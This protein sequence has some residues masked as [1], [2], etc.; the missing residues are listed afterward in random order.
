[1][2]SEPVRGAGDKGRTEY[3]V[4]WR[5]G[6]ATW[7]PLEHLNGSQQLLVDFMKTL[8]ASNTSTGSAPE[9]LL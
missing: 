2:T 7:E 4:Q 8:R 6:L 9:V 3:L 5:G 1:V